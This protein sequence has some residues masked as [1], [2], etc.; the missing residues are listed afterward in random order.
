MVNLEDLIILKY[1]QDICDVE[2]IEADFID[3]NLGLKIDSDN[4][5]WS[6]K[7]WNNIPVGNSRNKTNSVYERSN[8]IIGVYDTKNLQHMNNMVQSTLKFLKDVNCV[9]Y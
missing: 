2:V 5:T 8:F 4:Q 3:E 7:H 1:K 9:V 6:Y